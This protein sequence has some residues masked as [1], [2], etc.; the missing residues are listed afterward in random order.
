M[1]DLGL[2]D[3]ELFINE[4]YDFDSHHRNMRRI[5]PPKMMAVTTYNAVY[6][7][8]S[9]PG[10]TIVVLTT[11]LY[12]EPWFA[13]APEQYLDTKNK[14]ADA[15]LNLA[16][17][18]FPGLRD[19]A[20]VVEVSTP[21]TNARYAGTYHGGIYGFDQPPSNHTVLRFSPTGPLER[22]LHVGAWTQPGGGFHP[23]MLS[24]HMVAKQILKG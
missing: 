3:H 7:D 5:A 8:I 17:K 24:G 13:L 23:S 16:E 9:P 14:M 1:E 15:M 20:Q 21:V 10:T 19:N 22:L 12:G 2:T 4:D 6:P 18:H 11:L